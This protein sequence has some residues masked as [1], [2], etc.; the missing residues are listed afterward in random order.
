M[1]ARIGHGWADN[2]DPALQVAETA[3]L[4]RG[5]ALGLDFGLLSRLACFCPLPFAVPEH[6][7]VTVSDSK[8]MKTLA[9]L[10]LARH[11][12]VRY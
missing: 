1:P 4:Q 5:R 2:V 3:P 11:T 12:V 9:A 6:G 10:G 7:L 8:P